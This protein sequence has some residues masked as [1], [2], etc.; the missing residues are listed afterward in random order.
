MTAL[1]LLAIV[2]GAFLT[3]AMYRAGYRAGTAYA[4]GALALLRSQLADLDAERA[5]RVADAA[6][7]LEGAA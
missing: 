6:D 7:T 4:L 2:A 5:R 3:A 1:I